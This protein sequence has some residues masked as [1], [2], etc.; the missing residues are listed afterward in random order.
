MIMKRRNSIKAKQREFAI[1]RLFIDCYLGDI[2]NL[3]PIKRLENVNL[4]SNKLKSLKN[5]REN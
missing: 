3:T 1:K 2:L 4:S 5:E